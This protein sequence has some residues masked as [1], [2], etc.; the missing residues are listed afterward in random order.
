MPPARRR[1]VDPRLQV[2]PRG[3]DLE[4]PSLEDQAGADV[5]PAAGMRLRSFI[6]TVLVAAMAAELRA[7]KPGSGAPS[8]VEV[9]VHAASGEAVVFTKGAYTV[10]FDGPVRTFTES[11][12]GVTNTVVTDAWV[13]LLPAPFDGAV[14]AAER[15]WLE[16]RVAEN[17]AGLPD[18]LAH[19]MEYIDGAP[20]LYAGDL[21]VAGDA[22]YGPDDG[23]DFNDF[24]EIDW[25][26][27]DEG[28][29]DPWDA[30][31]A[32]NLDCSGYTRMVFGYRG[33]L[34]MSW[35]PQGGKTLPRRTMNLASSGTGVMVIPQD[36]DKT[37]SSTRYGALRAGDLVFFDAAGDD[38]VVDHTG[39][40]VGV[41]TAGAYRFINSRESMRGPTLRDGAGSAYGESPNPS[42]LS[43]G[44]YYSRAFRSARRL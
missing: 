32:G 25:S 41:D 4:V 14:D 42:I 35:D 11:K 7:G 36:R 6:P 26:Y 15:A 2:W 21:R 29:F 40:F 1:T 27:P 31:D 19:A 9:T 13:R 5:A 38:Q 22:G 17:T 37:V 44:G 3:L 16:A 43:G 28:R 33:G 20:D 18:V 39:I 23:G 30:V 24:L 8:Y 12:H 10:T 34:P